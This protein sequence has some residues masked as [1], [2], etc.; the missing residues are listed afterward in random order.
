MFHFS[1]IAKDAATRGESAFNGLFP[2][3]VNEFMSVRIP[4]VNE[5]LSP[6]IFLFIETNAP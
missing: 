6:N 3:V 1:L 5:S 2:V 4:P